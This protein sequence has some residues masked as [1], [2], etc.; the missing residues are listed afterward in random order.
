MGGV[1]KKHITK[2]S[3]NQ[4]R[5]HIF[6]KTASLTKCAKCGKPAL[7]HVVCQNCGYYKGVEV[8]N[9]LEKLTK[10]ERKQKEREIKEQEKSG[11]KE[12]SMEEMSK[13]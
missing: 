4:R 5:M 3:R 2:G 11:K 6:A 7:P 12:M 10:K 9:V 1:P 13:K 8:I